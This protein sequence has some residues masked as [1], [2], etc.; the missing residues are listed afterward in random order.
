MK[1]K[2][3]DTEEDNN[4]LNELEIPRPES[5]KRGSICKF[6]YV[7]IKNLYTQCGCI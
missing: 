3:G 6:L 4:K 7:I 5:H 2:T 1:D